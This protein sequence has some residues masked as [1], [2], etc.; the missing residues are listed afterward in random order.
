MKK[1]LYLLFAVTL[2]ISCSDSD[3][4]N[5]QDYTSFQ[6]KNNSSKGTYHNVVAGYRLSDN[7][8]K[9]IADLGDIAPGQLSEKIIIDYNIIKEVEI[10]FDA[11]NYDGTYGKTWKIDILKINEYRNNVFSIKDGLVITTLEID[12][13]DS[14]KYPQ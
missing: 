6:I 13:T 11:T 14:N 3:D 12:K 4:D 5:S 10:F 8:L 9:K 7:T 2:F 1:L